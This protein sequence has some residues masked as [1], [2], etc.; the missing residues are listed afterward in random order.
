MYIYNLYISYKIIYLKIMLIAWNCITRQIAYCH[1]CIVNNFTKIEINLFPVRNDVSYILKY[2]CLNNK[3]NNILIVNY[4]YTELVV[5]C[6]TSFF[7][8][9]LIKFLWTNYAVLYIFYRL[10]FIFSF[11]LV[12]YQITNFAH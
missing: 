1:K 10:N 6:F 12:K 9:L 4:S 8:F 3:I 11:C 7:S 2:V 5:L